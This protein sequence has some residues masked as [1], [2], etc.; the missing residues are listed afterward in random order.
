MCIRDSELI[1]ASIQQG[2]IPDYEGSFRQTIYVAMLLWHV[3]GILRMIF[4]HNFRDIPYSG[5]T[6]VLLTDEECHVCERLLGK[7]PDPECKYCEEFRQFVENSDKFEPIR[8]VHAH[9]NPY[10]PEK[11]LLA[12]SI[13]YYRRIGEPPL[14]IAPPKMFWALNMITPSG[15]KPLNEN[16]K[17]LFREAYDDIIVQTKGTARGFFR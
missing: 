10:R 5:D 11:S 1:T 17:E 9:Y 7:V 13:F 4:E 16:L 15:F 3:N 14:G 2:Y 8:L 6:V 12:Y